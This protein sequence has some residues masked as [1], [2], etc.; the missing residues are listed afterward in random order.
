MVKQNKWGVA[1]EGPVVSTLNEEISYAVSH[2]KAQIMEV[3]RE[4]KPLKGKLLEKNF[5][6]VLSTAGKLRA[7][8]DLDRSLQKLGQKD[9][10]IFQNEARNG[11]LF[12][13]GKWSTAYC[14]YWGL[15]TKNPVS[16]SAAGESLRYSFGKS[17]ISTAVKNAPATWNES[18]NAAIK[19][20]LENSP[21]FLAELRATNVGST[22]EA[23][24]VGDF[25]NDYKEWP[26]TLTH[27]YS[28]EVPYTSYESQ[29]KTVQ[30]KK[31]VCR[32]SAGNE[33]EI[34]SPRCRGQTPYSTYLDETVWEQVPVTRMRSE[35]RTYRHEGMAYTHNMD[36]NLNLSV[37]MGDLEL[38]IP[39]T[40]P[41]QKTGTHHRV[42]VPDIGLNPEP[43]STPTPL[44]WLSQE[45][46]KLAEILKSELQNKWFEFHCGKKI[47][48]SVVLAE[49]V[50]GCIAGNPTP[51]PSFVDEWFENRL[52]VSHSEA[53]ELF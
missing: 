50:L 23:K 44:E 17:R 7:I 36:V 5:P 37:K 28:V 52:G 21:F 47:D 6:G 51:T 13:L 39:L 9:C 33:E 53:Q 3:I 24:V 15:S 43:L 34:S 42:S 46:V 25:K 20:V 41:Y 45:K 30:K 14:A 2:L 49:K 48:G 12:Y 35:P 26:E 38:Q 16:L 4:E 32:T 27:S 19:S 10:A 8:A 29:A 18:N 1:P 31:L 11:K 22:A 40:D